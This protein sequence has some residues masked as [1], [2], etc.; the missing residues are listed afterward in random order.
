MKDL[1]AALRY[2][3]AVEASSNG[4]DE[5]G[6]LAAQLE[7]VAQVMESDPVVADALAGPGR[8]EERRRAPLDTLAK[9][10]RLSPKAS[11]LLGI[12][13]QHRRLGLLPLVAQQVSRI[14]D[15]RAGIVEAEVVSAAPLSP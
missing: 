2:A 4:M 11:A 14:H 9:A 3:R 10:A 7:A 15:R 5:L 12:L 1:A 8:P 13:A 6:S